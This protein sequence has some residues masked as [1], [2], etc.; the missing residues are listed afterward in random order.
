[1]GSVFLAVILS[2]LLCACDRDIKENILSGDDA[3][4]AQAVG[5][6]A[7]D[8][9]HYLLANYDHVAILD[10]AAGSIKR[11]VPDNPEFLNKFVPTSFAV[12][13]ESGRVFIANYTGNN[14]IVA[15]IDIAASSMHFE[16]LIGDEHTVSPEG[17]AVSGGLV[18]VANYDGNNVEFFDA[19]HDR[20]MCEI[21]VRYAHGVA[22]LGGFAYA[23]SLGDRSLIE[24]DPQT[25]KVVSKVG[26]RGWG[27]GRFLWPTSVAVWNNN[28]IAVSD[29][30]TGMISVFDAETLGFIKEFG[31]NGPGQNE[32]NMPYGLAVT[33]SSVFATSTFGY[34]IDRFDKLTGELVEGWAKEAQWGFLKNG[35]PYSLNREDRDAYADDQA[36]VTID[37]ACYHPGYAELVSCNGGADLSLPAL[38][39]SYMYFIQIAHDDDRVLIFS[40]QCPFAILVDKGVWSARREI[41]IGVD[42]WLIDGRVVGPS[43]PLQMN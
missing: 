25:C 29:A 3:G 4:Y 10:R 43:G 35:N 21:P 14:A 41:T 1:M 11:V 27:P 22:L 38:N 42:H 32:L 30:H 17:I 19:H 24:I 34:R 31:G 13:H 7:V 8:D 2:V 36:S 6:A 28:A 20:A 5:I 23:T 15:T 39:G 9:N 40:P 33:G 37:G 12:D 18:A 26:R 16:R